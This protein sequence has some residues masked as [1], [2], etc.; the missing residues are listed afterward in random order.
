MRYLGDVC[1][2]QGVF[3]V[4]LFNDVSQILPRPTLVAMATKFGSKLAITQVVWEISR[5]SL[6]LAGGFQGRAI[7]RRQS[8]SSTTDPGCHD[9]EIWA[10]I[11]YNSACVRDM[12]KILA[13]TRGFSWSGY[14]MMSVKFYRDRPLLPWQRIF[15]PKLAITRLVSDIYPRYLRPAKVFRAELLNDVSQILRRNLRNLAENWK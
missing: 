6:R 7:E 10:K 2:E 11:C 14:L 5:R 3:G 13:S 1:I 12:S 8:N 9:N 15:E 4:G